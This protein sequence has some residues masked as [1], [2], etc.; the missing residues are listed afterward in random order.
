MARADRDNL[1]LIDVRTTEEYAQGHIPGFQWFPGGQAVQRSDDVV[2]VK[3]GHVVF[4]CDGRVRATV[5]ASWYRQMGFPNVYVVD[6]GTTAWAASGLSLAKSLSQGG[7]GG[8][9]EGILGELPVGYDEAQVHVDL[10]TPQA[11]QTRLHNAQAPVVL[12]VDTS[13]DFSSGHV[14]G[15]HWVPRGW[16]EFWIDG[17]VPSKD[18][19]VVVTCVNG[20]NAVLAGATLKAL[21]YQRVAALAEGMQAWRKAGLP[22]EQGLSGVM[23]PPNDVLAMGT[24]RNWADAIHYLRWEEEL[25]KKYETE[26]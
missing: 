11:L 22:V 15:A 20:L 7:P 23:N 17:V 24:D 13:R 26:G 2:A 21:G 8:Y 1:Y 5:T 10:L 9:D 19:A 14:P 25:G 18:T 16:L 6:G 3:N 4:A 12:F